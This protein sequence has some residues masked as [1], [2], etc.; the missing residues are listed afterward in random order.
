MI[1]YE[2]IKNKGNLKHLIMSNENDES[3]WIPLED[4]VADIIAKHI[5]VI[6]ITP[7]KVV[8]RKNDETSD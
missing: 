1:K 4:A 7:T 6:S 5:A 2:G 3:I 8:E